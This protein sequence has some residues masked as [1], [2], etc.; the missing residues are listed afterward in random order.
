MTKQPTHQATEN[1]DKPL[2]SVFLHELNI[3][4]QKLSLY[5]PEHP[6]IVASC[7]STLNI[8]NELFQT[9]AIITLGIS[10]DALYF[11]QDWLDKENVSNQQFARFFSAMGIAS[12]SFKLGLKPQ[13]LIRFNQ[14]IRSD[15][16]T[17]ESFG[18]FDRLLEQQLIEH[19]SVVPINYDAFQTNQNNSEKHPEVGGQLWENFILGLHNGILDFGSAAD[20]DTVADIFNQRL[21][22]TELEREQSSH[23]IN[24]FVENSLHQQQD[25][26]AQSKND[27]NLISLLEQLT[28]EAQQLFLSSALP[29]LDRDHNA[30]SGLLK[31]IPAH[32]LQNTIAGKNRQ[33]LNLSSRLFGLINTLA[34]SP[35]QDFHHTI[36]TKPAPPSE[37]MVRARLDVLFTEER[38]DLYMPDSYQA[39]LYNILGDNVIGTI[40]EDEK[41]KLKDQIETQSIEINCAAIIFE[42]LQQQLD[43]EQEI[44]IQQ[45]LLDLSRYFLDTGNFK[46]LQ[47]IHNHWSK[48]LYSGNSSA[49][50]FNEMVLSHHVQ[51][52][53]MAEVLDGMDLWGEEK[54]Q[55]IAD[56]IVAVG[57]PYTELVIEYL[58]LAPNWSER[59]TWMKILADIGGDAQKVIV[60]FLKDDRWY[61]VRNLLM[62]LGENLDPQHIKAIHQLIDHP[63]PKVRVEVIRIL[64][65]CNPATANRQLLQELQSEEFEARASAVLIADLSRD[66]TVLS[67]LHKN[68]AGTPEN[69]NDLELRKQ[70]IQTLTRIGNR[71]SIPVFRRVL[72]KQSLLPSRRIK[73]LHR[74]I[75]ENLA[76]FPGSSAEKLLQELVSGKHKHLA[77]QALEKRQELT[78][79]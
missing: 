64:F 4:R 30:A 2:L 72:R 77:G 7:E 26:S 51:S 56:Y 5:P 40:P 41:Q 21:T 9:N 23:S 42:V 12:I 15:R 27:A 47:E 48:Y 24:L 67:I 61:L 63:H 45:N 31:K 78:R 28:P 32:L 3:S 17:I 36:K 62:I 22:G 65:S 59:Q 20:I 25:S 44:A 49:S 38:Q 79:S 43:A 18:G 46:L 52:T 76:L 29:A 11:E 54:Q 6:Q 75:F 55:Q 13:E 73:Q 8:L 69:E 57:E 66:P 74:E 19:I 34:T 1:D 16:K 58:G 53:F 71:E 10:P 39:A 68:L 50:I 14:L 60:R 35:Q 37:D 33:D 70:T